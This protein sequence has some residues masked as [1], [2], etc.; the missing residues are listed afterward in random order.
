[1]KCR[2]SNPELLDP[3]PV[4]LIIGML[5][6]RPEVFA[7]AE[8]LLEERYGEIDIRSAIIPFTFTNYYAATMGGNI[9]RK[10]LGFRELIR[11]ER[12]ATIKTETNLLET[13]ISDNGK[14]GVKRAVN[15]DP[16]YICKGKLVIA[17][18]KDYSHRIYLHRGIFAEVTLQYHSVLRSYRPQAWTFP[19]YRTDE[20]IDFFNDVRINYSKKE[21]EGDG[22]TI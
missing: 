4:N 1:M 6:S 7:T 13:D 16:G 22:L 21:M 12:I 8:S 17:T 15:L 5:S 10:F 18:T 20:Y 19:D 14:Y 3:E 2:N 9:E 11:P